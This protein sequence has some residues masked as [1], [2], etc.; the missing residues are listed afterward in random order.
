[1]RF[2][3]QASLVCVQKSRGSKF[4]EK[5]KH[6]SMIIKR[7]DKKKYASYCQALGAPLLMAALLFWAGFV[8]EY[9][10]WIFHASAFGGELALP[11]FIPLLKTGE[12]SPVSHHRTA[13]VR[14]GTRSL[15]HHFP[16]SPLAT[17]HHWAWKNL[18]ARPS[19]HPLEAGHSSPAQRA[20]AFVNL[21]SFPSDSYSRNC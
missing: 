17:F 3:R 18:A 15:R 13:T 16:L 2:C 10:F 11:L 1:M 20:R 14:Y 8:F 6:L 19:W 12:K 7:K 4:L 21:V 9:S 5:A